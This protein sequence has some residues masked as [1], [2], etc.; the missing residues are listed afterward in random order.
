MIKRKPRKNKLSGEE[1]VKIDPMCVYCKYYVKRT[2]P[3]TGYC[4]R[5]P[6]SIQP[7]HS[8]HFGHVVVE[9]TD[10]CGEFERKG[11]LSWTK[12]L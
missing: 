1:S 5:F 8:N 6:P 3:N 2:E 7:T 4:H 12:N 9:V 10:W 11:D